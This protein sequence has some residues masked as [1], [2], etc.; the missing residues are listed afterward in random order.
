MGFATGV[1]EDYTQQTSGLPNA[2]VPTV[3][4]D[5]DFRDPDLNR[6]L[7]V[8]EEL[9][10]SV[11]VVGDAYTESEA[12]EL[13]DVAGEILE[14]DPYKEVVVVPKCRSAFDVL[15]Q[16]VTLGYPNGYSEFNVESYS[17]VSDWRGRRVHLLGGSPPTQLNKIEE[18]TQPNLSDDPPA[19]IRGVDGNSVQ[20][21]AYFGESWSRSG[22]KSADH[23]SI[24]ETVR[25]SLKE[26]KAFWQDQGLWP[27][28]EP[29]DLYGEAVQKPD[30]NIFMDQG[31]DPIPSRESLENAY[32]GEYEEKGVLAFKSE[33]EKKFVEYREGFKPV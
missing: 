6:Y 10:P 17:T 20:K 28:T 23:L 27:D 12:E 8:F 22:Y 14:K 31:G 11:A 32:I 16:E 13:N 4:L 1:R 3:F 7:E 9:D 33:R 21:T 18:L 15:D 2:D 30:L 29:V 25:K 26:I 19:D 24:R 5:N